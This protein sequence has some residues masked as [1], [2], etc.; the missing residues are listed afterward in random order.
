[1]EADKG[2][3]HG[4]SL[5][6]ATSLVMGTMIGTGVFFKA[7]VMVQ[8]VGSPL[9]VLAAWAVAGVLSLTGALIY[10]ELGAMLPHAGGEYVFLRTA[11]GPGVGFM[12]GW[13]R[14][15]VMASGNAA[16]GV[17]CISFLSG[18]IPLNA[19]WLERNWSALG[20]AMHWQLG[21]REIAAVA[22]VLFFGFL[23]CAG[24][25]LGG[26][27]QLLLTVAKVLGIGL[28]VVGA[29]FLAKDGSTAHFQRPAGVPAWCGFSAFGAAVISALW[30]CD[31]WAF[32]P[33]VAGEV[34]N[35]GRNVPRAL[36]IG[37]LAALSLY[38]LVNLAYFYAMP[39]AEVATANSTAHRDALPVAAKAAQSFLG[40]RGGA[41][42]SIL[43]MI[44]AIGALNGVTL[45]T[46]RVPF[47]MA[48]DGLFF[49]RFGELTRRSR[50]PAWALIVFSI[51][52]AVLALS[53]TFDQL[54]NLAVFSMWLFYAMAGASVFVLRRKMP[55]APRPYRTLGYPVVPLLFVLTA[56][57]LIVNTL[58]TSPLEAIAGLGLI[59]L[60]WPVY[61]YYRRSNA[62][63][64][65]NATNGST[66]AARR[67]GT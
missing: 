19:V 26:R 20:L 18:L 25:V 17:G 41:I 13:M 16:L 6:S 2:L 64:K 24:V 59:A 52:S 37:V 4:L 62:Y 35:P 7:A 21:S 57:W 50:V 33:M 49:R 55:D 11:Y 48:R 27:V 54:T 56:V 34:K 61:L 46:A 51:W 38:T 43:F 42:A 22:L 1:M 15:V 40:Q 31:G 60:G 47:A 5:T 63:S 30:A 3:I 65:R 66:L 14:F 29:F 12:D 53:G 28:I 58:L 67:A 36:M 9:L 32:M 45:T 10:A 8:Q 23:N 39:L 44:S